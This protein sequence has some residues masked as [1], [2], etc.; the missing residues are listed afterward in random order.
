MFHDDEPAGSIVRGSDPQWIKLVISR[1]GWEYADLRYE[2]PPDP[3]PTVA[4]Q[5]AKLTPEQRAVIRDGD[6]VRLE[7]PL[8][9]A[10]GLDTRQVRFVWPNTGRVETFAGATLVV[11]PYVPRSREGEPAEPGYTGVTE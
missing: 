11:P 8:D 7:L 6:R 4:S 10:I 3:F 5:L 9:T 1:S 2:P